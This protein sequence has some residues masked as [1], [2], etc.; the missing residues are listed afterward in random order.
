MKYTVTLEVHGTIEVEVEADSKQAAM[1]Y[2]EDEIAPEV[3]L[4]AM[5]Y[6]NIEAVGCRREK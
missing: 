3:D 6:I 4:N 2:A 1:D 5:D